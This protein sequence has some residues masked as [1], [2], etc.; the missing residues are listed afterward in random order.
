M[1]VGVVK[2]AVLV[3]FEW[4]KISA[5]KQQEKYQEHRQ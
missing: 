2:A 4:R 5:K 1:N 3:Y